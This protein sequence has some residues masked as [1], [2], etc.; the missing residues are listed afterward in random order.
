MSVSIIVSRP[1]EAKI[2]GILKKM[3]MDEE[4]LKCSICD[5][6]L[7]PLDIR[8]I[9]PHESAL[10]CCKKIECLLTCR[11]RLIETGVAP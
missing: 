11:D 3:E 9:F 5:D 6:D 4:D 2:L 8:A 10:I 1:E 7:E